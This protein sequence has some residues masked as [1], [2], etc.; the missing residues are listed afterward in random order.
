MALP[1]PVA[2]ALVVSPG[3]PPPAAA[4]A[5]IGS[6]PAFSQGPATPPAGPSNSAADIP[7]AGAGEG[8]DPQAPAAPA[9]AGAPPAAEPPKRRSLAEVCAEVGQVIRADN[10]ARTATRKRPAAAMAPA[11]PE[12]AEG[13]LRGASGVLEPTCRAPSPKAKSAVKS[14]P[15]K[16]VHSQHFHK[17]R[18]E[19]LK[20]LVRPG[21]EPTEAQRA[22][23]N[24][25]GRKAAAAAV[26]ALP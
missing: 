2:P 25:A 8:P 6:P 19:V 26:A 22:K 9:K 10:A 14:D 7:P 3:I 1:A 13:E 20:R 11:G 16:L 17:A 23:A 18:S 15:R 24:A 21:Q 5:A 12:E 4:V